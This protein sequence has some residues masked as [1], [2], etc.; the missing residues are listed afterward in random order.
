MW[1]KHYNNCFLSLIIPE[2]NSKIKLDYYENIYRVVEHEYIYKGID[3][4]QI[5]IYVSDVNKE[6]QMKVDKFRLQ[7]ASTLFS[8]NEII[9]NNI[10]VDEDKQ[11]IVVSLED[12]QNVCLTTIKETI[13]YVADCYG[14]VFT[15]YLID[16]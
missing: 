3:I 9:I 2:I 11:S 7:L 15:E 5:N 12:L 4:E 8:E 14:L 16:I 1:N 13:E 10:T 6:V